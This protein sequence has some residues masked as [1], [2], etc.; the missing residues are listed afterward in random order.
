[1]HCAGI[2]I[3]NFKRSTRSKRKAATGAGQPICKHG[4]LLEIS[5]GLDRINPKEKRVLQ[6]HDSIDPGSNRPSPLVRPT[7]QHHLLRS[8]AWPCVAEPPEL[9]GP[10]VPTIVFQT[11]DSCICKPDNSGSLSGVLRETRVIHDF[12]SH[13]ESTKE[14]LQHY[15]I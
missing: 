9:Y 7:S 1:V 15:N 8:Q 11:S 5:S 13:T 12:T 3:E 10:H 2:W 14:L 4:P 6:G